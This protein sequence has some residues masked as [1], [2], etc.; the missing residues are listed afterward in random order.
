MTKD[1]LTLFL[2][3]ILLLSMACSLP[4]FSNSQGVLLPTPT[5]TLPP[6]PTATPRP[7]LPPALI[8]TSPPLGSEISPS[9]GITFYF[10]QPMQRT[11]VEAALRAESNVAGRF[12]WQD[13]ATVTFYPQ[14]PFALESDLHLT[15]ERSAQAQNGKELARPVP[16]RFRVA[17][18]LRATQLLPAP[19]SAD[20]SPS[21]A[22]VAAFNRPVVPLGAD[23]ASLPPAFSLNPPVQGRGEWL[24]TSTYIFYP[25]PAMLGGATYTAALN[26]ALQSAAGTPL[27]EATSWSFSTAKP[28]IVSVSPDT[29]AWLPLDAEITVAFNQPMDPASVEAAISLEG[30]A[31]LNF[32]WDDTFTTLTLSPSALL[33]YGTSYTLH[34]NA[35][36]GN[37]GGSALEKAYTATWTTYPRLQVIGPLNSS[38]SAYRS[39]RIAMNGRLPTDL[40]DEA[41][42]KYLTIS[43]AVDGASYSWFP[44]SNNQA[45][46]NIWGNFSPLTEYTV[47]I[48]PDLPDA[49]GGRLGN[50]ATFTIQTEA[51]PPSLFLLSPL[52]WS[53]VF[54]STPQDGGLAVQAA[55]LNAV[56]MRVSAVPLEDFLSLTTSDDYSSLQKYRPF[57]LSTREVILDAPPNHIVQRTLP[58]PD[59]QPGL[60]Y[61]R[62]NAQTSSDYPQIREDPFLLILTRVNLTFKR[63]A[64]DA[65][66]WATQM[67][68]GRPVAGAPV[69]IYDSGGALL[70]QGQT[71]AQGMFYAQNLPPDSAPNSF[72]PAV[73][74]LAKPGDPRFSLVRSDMNQGLPNG[75]PLL[76]GNNAMIYAYS[77]RPIYRPGQTVHFNI[78]VRRAFD[79]R[80][81]LPAE[82]TVQATVMDAEYN[83]LQ[84]FN[85]PLNAYGTTGGE[86]TLPESAP[87]GEYNLEVKLSG[88][89]QAGTH[90]PFT[91]AN[92]RKPEFE[93]QVQPAQNDLLAG[94]TLSAQVSAR[95][96]FDAPA[97]NLPVHWALYQ[98]PDVFHLPGYAVGPEE[99]HW[100]DFYPSFWFDFGELIAEG[101]G[102]TDAQGN[103]A[104]EIPL[105]QEE[106]LQRYT[107]EV[108]GTDESGFPIS[109]RADVH[110]HPA[111][112]YIGVR[113]EQ[114]DAPSG[115]ER[116][117]EMR[118]VDWERNPSGGRVLSVSFGRV[119][120]KQHPPNNPEGLSSYEKIITPV[121][122]T[123]ISTDAGGSAR[124]AFTPDHSGL[125]QITLRGEGALTE[126]LFWVGGAGQGTWPALPNQELNLEP[127]KEKYEPGETAQIF[128]PNPFGVDTQALVTLERSSIHY[129]ALHTLPSGGGM[130]SLPLGKAE[131]PNVYA[132]VT[133]VGQRADGLPD[134]RYGMVNLPVAGHHLQLQ[135]SLLDLPAQT[136]IRNDVKVRLRVTDEGGNPMQGVFSLAVVDK[137]VLA[138]SDP[139]SVPIEE[140]FYGQRS[141]EIST[142]IGLAAYTRRSVEE[143]GGLG[144]G[145]GEML[146]T[147][148]RQ[149]FP[150]TAFW[151]AE[152]VTDEKGE[153]QVSFETPD[154][155]TTWVLD[156]RGITQDSRVGS[157]QAELVVTKPLLIRPVTPRF[158]TL[159]DH[160][161]LAAIVHNNTGEPLQV[162]VQLQAPAFRLDDPSQAARTISLQPGEHQ[163]VDWWGTV[164]EADTLEVVFSAKG[165]R[166]SDATKPTWGDLPIVRYNAPQTYSTAGVLTEPGD[167][168]EVVSLPRSAVPTGGNLQIELAPSLAANM[169][170]GLDALAHY[171]YECT[172]QTLS[173]FLPNLA[174]YLAVQNLGLSAPDL[175]SRLERTLPDGLQRLGETQNEDGGWGWWPGD[176][177]N[178]Y[179]TAYVLFGILQAREAGFEVPVEIEK[180]V[181]YLLATLAPVSETTQDAALD[182]QAPVL[183]ALHQ[184]GRDAEKYR[185]TLFG[186][187][188]R[189]SP[190]SQAFLALSYP[191]GSAEAD[192]L[193]SDLQGTAIRSASG[194]HWEGDARYRIN[195]V[196]DVQSTAAVVYALALRQPASTLVPDAV[197]YLMAARGAEGWGSTYETAWSLLAM[198]AV[199]QGTGELAGDFDF[200]AALNGS[201]LASGN[202]AGEAQLTPVR[203]SVP[204]SQ[205]YPDQPN[206]LVFSHGPG[207]GRLYYRAILNVLLPVSNLQPLS[208]GM[209]IS[210]VYYPQG[211]IS[212]ENRLQS[213]PAGQLVEVHLTLSLPQD[214]HYV[215]VE[216][217][218]PAGAEILDTRLKTSQQEGLNPDETPFVNGW[219]WWLF[220]APQ[221]Y[222]DRIVWT[223]ERLP[224][225]TYELTYTLVLNQPGE[226]RVLPAHAYEFYFPEVQARSTGEL[227]TIENGP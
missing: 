77:D 20:V 55:S 148:V 180:A 81:E 15:L 62:L 50:A 162:D 217:Y 218:L 59:S 88:Q 71:D 188:S 186:Y 175:E 225:G 206:A 172:E 8:E 128:V 69:T 117:F 223:A 212:P 64:R 185:D 152:I 100:F 49:W 105:P 194:A 115:N 134:F 139:N 210:R 18:P 190:A 73:A 53:N 66:V 101:D 91:V 13:D 161:P 3:T 138:L 184:A 5:P 90:L 76:A 183:L 160:F 153:A 80:Y 204:I 61:V 145:G 121:A 224:A 209:S 89:E 87:P 182:R 216:D 205:L 52:A 67:E 143:P 197:R 28:Q 170:S 171:P 95:Y 149:K 96:Y 54:L 27:E 135:V 208:Q 43:P 102:Y 82:T 36:A 104:L 125:Y 200:G 6:P 215:A 120:W 202:A 106:A 4:V 11:S 57:G 227:F 42:A 63:G 211:Q 1:R 130:I 51:L 19:G 192:V 132:T 156:V 70:A 21:S 108:T 86:Y 133:L 168:L 46:I 44:N 58:L 68:D 193:L 23:Q 169:V 29:S 10:N 99:I 41:M 220:S 222:D 122:E 207:Q 31:T 126:M 140:A 164:G 173:R 65:L 79:G 219:M 137:A 25:Q 30:A 198:S 75:Y 226:Y 97:G 167:L 48:S 179:I 24:N 78:V 103:L 151:Q 166:W 178:P 146:S 17:G 163:R 147:V 111:A 119:T 196:S 2:T 26:P 93:L 189:L 9:Q 37:A 39:M 144:G 201:P 118:T 127:D 72:S 213:A 131:A 16:I 141:L 74:V 187:R 129:Y 38:I 177:S 84:V 45:V 12:E 112:F 40:R 83:A 85:L 22:I 174:A 110:A 157:A 159:G 154:N 47:S 94:Q 181:D 32:T 33:A 107:L 60:Y 56:Q 203:S 158:V 98:H 123:Q 199:M 113:A 109:A 150:D 34:I 116:T 155:L 35:Q 7:D 221:V 114:W 136:G 214:A 176:E 191:P 14:T 165:G 124:V 142:G 92:Y 195:L